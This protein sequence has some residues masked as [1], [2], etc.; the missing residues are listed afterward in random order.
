MV[1]DFGAEAEV[2][3]VGGVVEQESAQAEQQA[4]KDGEDH[5]QQP[6]DAEGIGTGVDDCFVNHL[7]NQEGIDQ[8]E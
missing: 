4:F 7:L 2:E 8:A 3:A 5:Q 1:H 6:E